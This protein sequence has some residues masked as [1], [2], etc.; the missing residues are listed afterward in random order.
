MDKNFVLNE[1]VEMQSS[2]NELPD[3]E[4]KN[5]LFS[6][7]NVIIHHVVRGKC[8]IQD[9]PKTWWDDSNIEYR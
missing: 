8:E 1:L 7:V 2:L 3:N 6:R 4:L 9:D 5:E